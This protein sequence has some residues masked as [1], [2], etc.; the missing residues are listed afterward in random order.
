MGQSAKNDESFQ[1]YSFMDRKSKPLINRAL[2][3]KRVLVF[4]QSIDQ[5]LLSSSIHSFIP[6]IFRSNLLTEAVMSKVFCMIVVLVS[7]VVIA[8]TGRP[9]RQSCVARQKH[10]N[11]KGTLDFVHTRYHRVEVGPTL[12]NILSSAASSEQDNEEELQARITEKLGGTDVESY[13]ETIVA[14]LQV[15]KW[16]TVRFSDQSCKP[17]LV[18]VLKKPYLFYIQTKETLPDLV[19]C[20]EENIRRVHN[21]AVS[22]ALCLMDPP[23]KDQVERRIAT[24]SSP[25][26]PSRK[27]NQDL[28]T[29]ITDKLLGTNLESDA[30]TINAIL[31]VAM[32]STTKFYD[33]INKPDL[34]T[35]LGKPYLF[36]IQNGEMLPDLVDF[37]E[38][39][40]RRVHNAA[41]PISLQLME[42]PQS[43][44]SVEYADVVERAT[45]FKKA[46]TSVPYQDVP[47][48]NAFP[49]RKYN[50]D[51]Q[52]LITDKLLGTNLESDAETINAI[53]QVAMWN[54]TKFYD[55]INK[56][57]LVTVL[58]KPYL[59]YIQ[60]GEMLPNL[61]DFSEEAIRRVH[62]AA[63]PISLQLMETPQSSSSVEYA[64]VV[65]HATLFKKAITSVPYQDVPGGNGMKALR[66]IPNLETGLTSDIVVRKCTIP[67]WQACIDVSH[68]EG[69]HTRVCAVGSPGIGKTTTIPILIRTLLE[70]NET[71]VY[72]GRTEDKT[73]W[74][75]EFTPG[76]DDV[77]IVYP[78]YRRSNE[79]MSLKD[80]NTTF[81]VDAGDTKDSCLPKP[82][83]KPRFI[84]VSSPDSRHWGESAFMKRRGDVMG[85][86]LHY[87]VWE[88]DELLQARRIAKP[89][90]SVENVN[91][92]YRNFGGVPRHVFG[93]ETDREKLRDAL[94]REVNELTLDQA[95]DLAYGDANKVGTYAPSQPKSSLIA[96]V[97]D[98][99]HKQ[100]TKCKVTVISCLATEL[101]A[102]RFM[103]K[104]WNRVQSEDSWQLFE[105]Y[106]RYLM[107]KKAFKLQCRV[108]CS[109]KDKERY[110]DK[111]Y[112]EVGG[113]SEIRLAV[114]IEKAAFETRNV[115]FHSTQKNNPL[116]DF[117]YQ[118]DSNHV[119][120]FQVA[121]G[122]SHS[123]DSKRIGKLAKQAISQGKRLT[124]YYLV[125]GGKFGSFQTAPADP[126]KKMDVNYCTILH[127]LIPK[128]GL[129]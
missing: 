17:D 44:S 55:Q 40:I 60:N 104:L 37:S 85:A 47:G 23:R 81:I 67:F 83:F 4:L 72:L 28:Q 71:V 52:T 112:T 1:Y 110:D 90:L 111:F 121:T 36:Y 5:S 50:Q 70:M 86:F 7:T 126:L 68:E 21:A 58:G 11:P 125:M 10:L 38:E 54:T 82:D 19:D 122:S 56:P 14:I 87:P 100:F 69:K 29:R 34:V 101:V 3:Q 8:F 46:I 75:Y 59:F 26:F 15:A 51:L 120:A 106:C 95:T 117:I 94:N 84:L 77:P 13:T 74:Y 2:K 127:V 53:L 76:S 49:S 118:D 80:P 129:E 16:N 32:W 42:A 62:N 45:L 27:Y 128:P 65:E 73:S 20:S 98:S 6:A 96:Y 107:L 33:P 113:C 18:S 108:C 119:R 12:V 92:L 91:A 43:S 66:N 30:E 57:D 24:S 35:V 88:L 99:D 48:G 79:I 64:D 9:F 124:L 31:Q 114:D 61:V 25:S 22:I 115:V 93:D 78:E 116:I 89:T 102:M 105:A 41:I 123:A 103:D 63:I 39:A 109:S 97:L